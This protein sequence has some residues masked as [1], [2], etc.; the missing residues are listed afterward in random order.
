MLVRNVLEFLQARAIPGK[1][2]CPY[3]RALD[4]A[5]GYAGLRE[6]ERATFELDAPVRSWAVLDVL[7]D[8]LVARY[9][10]LLA[11]RVKGELAD[12]LLWDAVDVR[13]TYGP[14]TPPDC[15]H[16]CIAILALEGAV[17]E[18]VSPNWDGLI[19]A[20]FDDLGY[21]PDEVVRV[22]VLPEDLREPE[23]A[24]TLI[25]FHGC[26]VLA[27]KDPAR[28]RGPLV[29]TRPQITAWSTI[30][31]TKVIRTKLVELA[32]T[33]PTLVVGLSAQDE[34]IQQVFAQAK[35]DMTWAWPSDP[36][37]HIF[38]GGSLGDHHVNIL[39]VVYSAGYDEKADEIEH[40]ALVPAYAKQFMTALVLFV[41]A[42]KLRAYVAEVDAPRLPAADR[43]QLADGL[44]ELAHRLADAAE[45]DRLA[46][47]RKLAAGQRRVV[48]LFQE[49][50]E[51]SAGVP[52]YKP[53]GSL[54][55]GRVKIDTALPTSGVRE[56]A[57]A[58]ALLGRGE[59]AGSWSLGTGPAASGALKVR[60][61][62][63][64]AAIFFVANGKAALRLQTEGLVDPAAADAVIIHSTEPVKPAARSPRGTD[65]RTGRLGIREVDMCE[66]LT[67][68]SDL[69]SLEAGFRQAAAL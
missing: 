65:G 16:L 66:L 25:K 3:R 13:A 20:A 52:A 6:S 63:A 21:D 59:A 8:G 14:G 44:T 69:A 26:A 54:P 11:I 29:A 9:S 42:Q 61:S 45:P 4:V 1:P 31:E 37:G 62:G 7:L 38:A 15:E 60:S 36:P 34:N 57:A 43:A 17:G 5:V 27:G 55:A 10:E 50:T 32:T 46:F 64:D 39:R 28:Y 56:L 35:A 51:P 53:L 30:P 19:E 22:V 49:G 47:I 2:D 12:Y 58:L 33:K 68:S 41:L 24:L 18:A 48:T 67:A 40:E 23:R